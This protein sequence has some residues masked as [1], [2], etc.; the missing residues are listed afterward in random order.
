V[1]IFYA[2]THVASITQ[3][4][5]APNSPS[6]RLQPVVRSGCMSSLHRQVLF[7]VVAVFLVGAHHDALAERSE[8]SS[9]GEWRIFFESSNGTVSLEGTT[10][11]KNYAGQF[12]IQCH[13]APDE[14]TLILPLY[15]RVGR[16]SPVSSATI[17][18]WSDNTPPKDLT[19]PLVENFILM[20][21]TRHNPTRQAV[22]DFFFVLAN[23][24][25]FFA[26]SNEGETF[27]YD[28]LHLPAAIA[29]FQE[30]C[31]K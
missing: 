13:A 2:A 18:V 6:G 21:M 29:R 28:V 30:R 31:P 1:A 17:T 19:L 22:M 3:M 16:K 26:Y 10:K 4:P 25:K 12:T 24:K 15:N 8:I 9:F 11:S 23:S 27:Q 14:R 20:G 5:R 7:A